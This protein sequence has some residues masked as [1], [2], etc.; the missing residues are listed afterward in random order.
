[1][2]CFKGNGF[3]WRFFILTM[4]T[5]A[6]SCIYCC[7]GRRSNN[8]DLEIRLHR[9]RKSLRN[10]VLKNWKNWRHYAPISVTSRITRQFILP[11]PTCPGC[12][13]F[14]HTSP[15][16]EKNNKQTTINFKNLTIQVVD[17]QSR[18]R[19][20]GGRRVIWNKSLRRRS[21]LSRWRCTPP[22]VSGR[23]EER[24]SRSRKWKPHY[25]F[26]LAR[27]CCRCRGQQQRIDS[28]RQQGCQDRLREQH[29]ENG[30]GRAW[31]MSSKGGTQTRRQR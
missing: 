8:Q 28:H 29:G 21:R 19:P 4:P 14:W 25:E 16:G 7:R 30:D 5:K 1:M 20:L 23:R 10:S 15:E 6:T 3:K 31:P 18:L 12:M 13:A 11:S 22:F 26:R 27:S 9:L 17:V 24:R 2:Q